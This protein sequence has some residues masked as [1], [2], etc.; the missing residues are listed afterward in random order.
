[1]SDTPNLLTIA[2]ELTSGDRRAAYD[3]PSVDFQCTADLWKALLTRAGY[4]TETDEL[5]AEMVPVMM[6]AMKLSRLAGN[7]NHK[8]SAIDI[9]GYMRTLEMVWERADGVVASEDM[10]R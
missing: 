5:P 2:N 4:G 1:M 10:R 7:L 9:A 6:A 3:H 8:D